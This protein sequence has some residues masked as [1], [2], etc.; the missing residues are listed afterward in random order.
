MHVLIFGLCGIYG[1]RYLY[2]G[3]A[4]LAFR[5]EQPLNN[6]LLRIW[7][8]IYSVV[9]MQ[10]GWR[11]RPCLG[12]QGMPFEFLRVDGGDGNFYIAVWQSLMNLLGF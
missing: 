4:Y 12:A 2:R 5:M 10:L 3:S 9:G 8:V 7:I 1:V 11:L 6:T